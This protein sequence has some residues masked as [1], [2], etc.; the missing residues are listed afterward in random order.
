MDEG[1]ALRFAH[2]NFQRFDVLFV[3]Y[4]LEDPP[5]RYLSLA[6]EGITVRER[7]ALVPDPGPDGPKKTQTEQDWQRRHVD[8]IWYSAKA[9]D[10]RALE[11]T[12]NAW[13]KDNSRSFLDRRNLLADIG[14]SKPNHLK[15]HDLNRAKFFYRI[16]HH[17]ETSQRLLWISTGLIRFFPGVTST[18]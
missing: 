1:W 8:P 10:Y 11:R 9:G 17:Y 13:G 5:L 15:P 18:S 12:I 3:G 6:L 16:R 7:W 4:R 2:S 14:K